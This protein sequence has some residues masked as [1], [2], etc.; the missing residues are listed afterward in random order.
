[1]TGLKQVNLDKMEETRGLIPF[2]LNNCMDVENIEAKMHSDDDY[3][4]VEDKT[5]KIKSLKLRNVTDMAGIS[6]I[7]MSSPSLES[8]ELYFESNNVSCSFFLS[9]LPRGLKNLK[10]KGCGNEMNELF[11]SPAMETL[12]VME[13]FDVSLSSSAEI[14]SA[15]NLTKL[16]TDSFNEN[17]LKIFAKKAPLISNLVI[18]TH[19]DFQKFMDIDVAK[20]QYTPFYFDIQFKKLTHSSFKNL[21]CGLRDFVEKNPFLTELVITNPGYEDW[22][23]DDLSKLKH[24]TKLVYQT[25][26]VLE[27]G[28]VLYF[29]NKRASGDKPLQF[30]VG[31]VSNKDPKFK[32][33]FQED[34]EPKLEKLKKEVDR[35][36]SMGSN[37]FVFY[38]EED[39]YETWDEM[40]DRQKN[41]HLYLPEPQPQPHF[42]YDDDSVCD[43][44]G[45]CGCGDC[46]KCGYAWARD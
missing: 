5:L 27:P 43:C 45:I 33:K 22:I 42:S 4:F 36:N 3:L 1:M 24:L 29:L 37:I 30:T 44:S 14:N 23:L 16:C 40:R 32:F 39:A 9:H 38:V 7:M 19:K 28:Y 10:I 18:D 26:Q 11:S 13:L 35:Q 6:L 21:S 46:G 17:L 20:D 25:N 8:L 41:R 34:D 2:I 15:I 31:K 12:Q